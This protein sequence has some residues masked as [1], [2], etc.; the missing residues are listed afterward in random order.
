MLEQ[1]SAAITDF[2]IAIRLKPDDVKAYYNRGNAKALLGRTLEAKQDL[3]TALRLAKQ[4]G[5]ENFRV[6]IEKSLHT[7][8]K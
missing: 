7:L 3:R 4:V 8:S 2:D 6:K 5:A 1:H